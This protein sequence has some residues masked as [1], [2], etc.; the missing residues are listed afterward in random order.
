MA[1]QWAGIVRQGKARAIGVSN[2]MPNHLADIFGMMTVPPAVN[3][4]EWHVGLHDD[5][6]IAECRD[7]NITVTA[8][9]PLAV[10]DVL[11]NSAVAQ[12]AAAH[13]GK[14]AAQVAIR[15]LVQ[16]GATTIPGANTIPYMRQDLDVFGWSLTEQ[17]MKLLDKQTTPGR[18]YWDPHRI[19]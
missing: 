7:H 13:P 4:F 16:H 2:F 9:A 15:W 3:Q 19:P 6:L 14:T 10:G 1:A 5:G 11:N 8:Y 17:E 12:I 18:K